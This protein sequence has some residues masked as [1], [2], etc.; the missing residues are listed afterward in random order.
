MSERTQWVINGQEAPKPKAKKVLP[1][2]EALEIT[3][4]M[5]K[6]QAEF[7]RGWNEMRE[8]LIELGEMKA[9]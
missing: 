2:R 4:K 9:K 8:R 5:G 1:Y 6:G 7:A 3:D